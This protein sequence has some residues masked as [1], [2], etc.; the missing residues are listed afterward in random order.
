MR[1]RILAQYP[2]DVYCTQ[3]GVIVN[4]NHGTSDNAIVILIAYLS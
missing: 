4:L 2:L 3:I 1:Y